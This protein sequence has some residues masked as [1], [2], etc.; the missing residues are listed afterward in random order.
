MV[1]DDMSFVQDDPSPV[2]L[3]KGGRGA[4]TLLLLLWLHTGST[5]NLKV[6]LIGYGVK[7]IECT[8]M[9]EY[10]HKYV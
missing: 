8:V 1:P 6:I 10:D 5:L 2:D 7:V 3:E 4:G 9:D